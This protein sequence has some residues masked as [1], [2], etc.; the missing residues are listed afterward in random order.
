M[1]FSLKKKSILFVLVIAVILSCVA[2]FVG[3]RIYSD[4]MD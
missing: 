2:V 3:Y 1:Q 4:T